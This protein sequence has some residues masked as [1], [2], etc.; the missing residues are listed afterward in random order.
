MNNRIK[1]TTTINNLTLYDN[2][3]P[4]QFIY[5][6][7]Q[8]VPKAILLYIKLWQLKNNNNTVIIQKKYLDTIFLIDKYTF[9]KYLIELCST[10]LVSF[11]DQDEDDI[12]LYNV[13]LTDWSYED[14]QATR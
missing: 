4:H 5:I 14:E 1:A 10:G 2:W 6:I 3:P 8:K 9:R 7:A 12:K 13:E 11:E